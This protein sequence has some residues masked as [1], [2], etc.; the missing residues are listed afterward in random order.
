MLMIGL[1]VALLKAV[2]ERSGSIFSSVSMFTFPSDV[3]HTGKF[4]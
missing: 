1:D 3:Y 4:H 2:K